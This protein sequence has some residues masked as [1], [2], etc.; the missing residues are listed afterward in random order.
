MSDETRYIPETEYMDDLSRGLDELSFA[1]LGSGLTIAAIARGT[2][3]HWE[4]VS[5]AAKRIPVRYDSYRRIMYFL[6]S[7]SQ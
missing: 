6:K 1:I 4:T 7:I 3:C 5:N 2:R